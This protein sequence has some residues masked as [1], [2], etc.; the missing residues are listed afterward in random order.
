MLA[1]FEERRYNGSLTNGLF[2]GEQPFERWVYF[3]VRQPIDDVWRAVYRWWGKAVAVVAPTIRHSVDDDGPARTSIAE[4]GEDGPNGPV[5]PGLSMS[6]PGTPVRRRR[7]PD[8]ERSVAG[9]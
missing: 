7:K 4:I 2:A 6:T 9:V 1:W 3:S 5:L 8:R